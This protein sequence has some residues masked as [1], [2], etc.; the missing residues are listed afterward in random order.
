MPESRRIGV[1]YTCTKCHYVREITDVPVGS[2][3]EAIVKGWN[4]E[5]RNIHP[6]DCLICS[7]QEVKE[8]PKVE[9][10]EEEAEVKTEEKTEQKK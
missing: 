8:E 3:D 2:D 5:V 6:D 1:I 4:H 9:E 7:K 10:A